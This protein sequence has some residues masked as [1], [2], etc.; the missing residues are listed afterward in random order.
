MLTKNAEKQNVLMKD[1][2]IIGLR[3]TKAA[4]QDYGCVQNVPIMLDMIKF[5]EK[6]HHL[7]TM[8]LRQEAARKSTKEG[9]KKNKNRSSE[10]NI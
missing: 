4:V 6:C 7:Y 10:E 3:A 1:E 8:H 2:T 9:E 5:V